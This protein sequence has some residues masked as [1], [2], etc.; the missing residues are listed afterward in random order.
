MIHRL[1]MAP[2]MKTLLLTDPMP[3][4]LFA[5]AVASLAPEVT[6]LAHRRDIAD[7]ELADV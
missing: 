5:D 6:L 1:S 3:A 4:A 7:D 2:R